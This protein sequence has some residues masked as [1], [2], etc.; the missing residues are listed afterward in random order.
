MSE[1][2]SWKR[3]AALTP[4]RIALGRAGSG[5]PTSET[6]RFALAHARARDAVHAALDTD[7]L[8]REVGRIGLQVVRVQSRAPTRD[9]YLLRPDLGRRLLPADR[10]AVAAG[11]TD[12]VD[13]S[14]TIA[15][16]LS[17][18]AVQAH[19][20]PVLRSLVDHVR[21]A[22]WRLGPIAL[23]TQGRVALADEIGELQRARLALILLG[24]RPGLSTP[25]SLGLYLTYAP[26]PGR[27]DGE[28]NCISNVHDAG[29]SAAEAAARAAWLIREA[30][31]RS[32]TGVALKD[33]S[34]ARSA[35]A[36]GAG[37]GYGD[38]EWPPG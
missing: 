1:I 29:L 4:A 38:G 26:R 31:A 34:G 25:D 27:Q 16:G 23:A 14:I 3:L 21:S 8:A 37:S 11:A 15:D 5:L 24:E 17:A 12:P 35:G 36:I 2:E 22:G 6:L 28:R 13:L 7:M 32:L 10:E 20:L 18:S 9:S 19:A 33:E 30:F